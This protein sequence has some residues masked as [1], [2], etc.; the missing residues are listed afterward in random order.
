MPFLPALFRWLGLWMEQAKGISLENIVRLGNPMMH[1]N[2]LLDIF[3]NTVNKT[4]ASEGET[5]RE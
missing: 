2:Q 4:Q 3:H 1:P 5:G